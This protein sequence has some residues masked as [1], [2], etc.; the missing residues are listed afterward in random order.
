MESGLL[1]AIVGATIVD[2]VVRAGFGAAGGLLTVFGFWGLRRRVRALEDRQT[3]PAPVVNV[4][5]QADES[6]I[7]SA[8]SDMETRAE[9]RDLKLRE[10]NEVVRTL[11]QRP[12]GG[13]HTVSALPDGTNVVTMA[14]G[15]IRLAL[16]V[17]IAGIGTSEVGGSASL[18][19]PADTD[20]ERP[21]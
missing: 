14:D 12:L 20:D 17:R 7:L 21:Q 4:Y 16:P 18:K 9:A 8:L 11:P 2:F 15:T 6:R 13:G 10:F 19:P 5:N 1:E 3:S